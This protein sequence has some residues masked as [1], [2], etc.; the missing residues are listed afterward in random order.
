VGGGVLLPV[1]SRFFFSGS[2]PAKKNFLRSADFQPV[3]VCRFS[4][5]KKIEKTEFK[6]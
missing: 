4:R 2:V 6:K 1:V 3:I 5:Y